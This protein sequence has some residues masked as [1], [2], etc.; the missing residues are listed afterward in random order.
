ME[1]HLRCRIPD[2][3]GMLATLA[4]AISEAGGDIQAVEV[5]EVRDGTAIDDL[6]VVTDDLAQVVDGVTALDGV[7]LVH[8]GFSRGVPGDATARLATGIDALMSGAMP[9]EQG[10]ATLLG[11]VLRAATAEIVP[12]PPQPARKDRRTLRLPV[13]GGTLVLT[14]EYRFLDS[15]I[16]RARQVLT[17]C[18]RATAIAH[19]V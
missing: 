13:A 7:T 16:Q 19:G 17:V 4:G 5:V 3:R 9:A 6:W 14:R 1:V 8:R 11:G 2:T 12:G 10:L 18:E 15:E